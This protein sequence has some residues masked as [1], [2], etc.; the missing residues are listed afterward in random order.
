M[1]YFLLETLPSKLY[2]VTLE[3]FEV[4]RTIFFFI[5]TLQNK[6]LKLTRR[7][8]RSTWQTI[9]FVEVGSLDNWLGQKIILLPVKDIGKTCHHMH[10]PNEMVPVWYR[11]EIIQQLKK[12]IADCQKLICLIKRIMQ[13]FYTWKKKHT[14][15]RLS[16]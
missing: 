11:Y 8:I 10:L 12:Y 3:L 4:Q 6:M 9:Y 5:K 2:W 14:I 13:L 7:N 15:I 1:S 16:N